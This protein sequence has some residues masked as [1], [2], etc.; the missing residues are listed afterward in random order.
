MPSLVTL[1]ESCHEYET[2]MLPDFADSLVQ[3]LKQCGAM[4]SDFD[5]LCRALIPYTESRDR[6]LEVYDWSVVAFV[7]EELLNSWQQ[8]GD[9]WQ[10][11]RDRYFA[12]LAAKTKARE[13]QHKN[14]KSK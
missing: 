8:K 10:Q 1:C 7:L 13:K 2:D 12:M 9:L 14:D 5:E 11:T 4:S 6:A 3:M